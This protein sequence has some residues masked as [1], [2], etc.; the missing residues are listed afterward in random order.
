MEFLFVCF[1]SSFPASAASYIRKGNSTGVPSQFCV[2]ILI[3]YNEKSS[4]FIYMQY[5]FKSTH[6]VS[7]KNYSEI[8]VL[9][10]STA[11]RRIKFINMKKS[12]E[13]QKCFYFVNFQLL[14]IHPK[15][16]LES[17]L[18]LA[19]IAFFC[20][21]REYANKLLH[22]QVRCVHEVGSSFCCSF[23]SKILKGRLCASCHSTRKN[24]ILTPSKAH[25]ITR[26]MQNRDVA[27]SPSVTKQ[28]KL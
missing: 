21:L 17:F 13:S 7:N 11:S 2:K 12:Q 14:S 5:S 23:P 25:C 28:Q 24:V 9:I 16:Q 18:Y 22:I 4:S 8:Q 10:S 26:A 27:L 20:D 15:E 6:S 1:F 3:K 19:I